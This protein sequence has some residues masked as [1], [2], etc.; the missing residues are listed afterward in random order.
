MDPFDTIDIT[1]DGE[2]ISFKHGLPVT[3]EE[4]EACFE[5]GICFTNN[6]EKELMKES[7]EFLKNGT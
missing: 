5:A 7:S 3:Y 4:A 6:A 2:F 1:D